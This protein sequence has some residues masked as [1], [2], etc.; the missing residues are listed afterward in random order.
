MTG[1][2]LEKKMFELNSMSHADKSGAPVDMFLGRSVN[3]LLPNAGNKVLKMRKEVERRKESQSRWMRRLGRTTA[4]DFK[5]GD[6]VRVQNSRTGEWDLKG[7]VSDVISHD[8][9][10]LTY[11]VIGDEGGTYLRNGRFIKLRLSKAR[12]ICHVT[13][14]S[15]TS[16][17]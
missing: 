16:G 2:K 4:S 15:C 5:R 7:E 9:G 3:S 13:F 12:K 10:S 14:D 8:G 1:A 11:S 17:G 6:K